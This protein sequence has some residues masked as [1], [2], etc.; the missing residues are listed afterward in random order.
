[1]VMKKMLSLVISAML[2]ISGGA[3]TK[4]TNAKKVESANNTT[5]SQVDKKS[6]IK[7][8]ENKSSNKIK[9]EDKSKSDSKK[10]TSDEKPKTSSI[11][12]SN[13]L[14]SLFEKA[15]YGMTGAVYTPVAVLESSNSSYLVLCK[16]EI[17]VPNATPTYALVSLNEKT[18]GN[19]EITE[20][21][22][23]K[24]EAVFVD[25][26][27]GWREVNSLT[28]DKEAKAAFDTAVKYS[29]YEKYSPIALLG[30]Q[31]VSGMNYQILVR[32]NQSNDKSTKYLILQI[33]QPVSD[34]AEITAVYEFKA[35]K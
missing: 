15:T 9:N 6:E 4:A 25:A 34:T 18:N 16:V 11:T 3:G 23:S 27:G 29:K 10:N 5:I 30:Q 17:A 22:D 21:K 33:Y 14:K 26:P 7:K 19:A 12:V 13:K 8:D 32:T 20:V 28:L 31:V 2:G 24:A 35:E 1:M